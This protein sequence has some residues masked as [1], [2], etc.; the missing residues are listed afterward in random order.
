M[1]AMRRS[2]VVAMRVLRRRRYR[3]RPGTGNGASGQKVDSFGQRAVVAER[4]V[5]RGIGSVDL[6]VRLAAEHGVAA[7]ASLRRSGIAPRMLTDPYAEIE[8]EQELAVV[9]NIVRLIGHVPGLGLDAGRR[10]HL[11]AYGIWGYV[12]LAS[13]TLGSA[14]EVGIR[15]LDLTFAFVRFRAERSRHELVLWLDDEAIPAECRQFLLE[16]DAAAAVSLH[17]EL[18]QAAIPLR[19]AWFRGPQPPYAGRFADFFPGPVSFDRPA[20]LLALD[21]ALADRA[22]PQANEQTARVCEEQCRE[23]LDRR[24]APAGIAERVRRSLLRPGQPADMAAVARVLG[25][26]PRSLHRHLAAEGTTYR[27]LVGEVR[28]ALADEM[29]SHRMSVDEVAER[30][31]YAEPASFIHAF[32]RWRGTSPGA[33]RRRAP[34]R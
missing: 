4:S 7:P 20:N 24:R 25:M 17:R 22:L 9:R 3:G 30:L 12:L 26:A 11:T 21:A 1:M 5:R 33:Y 32:R 2:G 16:R 27:R 14:I 18:F 29:L 19:R 31:G 23:L 6:L 10:Y 28:S 8:A 34:A 15:Y 13:R